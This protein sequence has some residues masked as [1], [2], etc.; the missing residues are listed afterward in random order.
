MEMLKEFFTYQIVEEVLQ[1]GNFIDDIKERYPQIDEVALHDIVIETITKA[2]RK[3][4][5]TLEEYEQ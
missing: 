3:S 5:D 4:L 2:V 1:D